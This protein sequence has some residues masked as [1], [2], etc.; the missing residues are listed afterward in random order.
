MRSCKPRQGLVAPGY[1][2]A[3]EKLGDHEHRQREDQDDQQG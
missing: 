1:G 3:L 2:D